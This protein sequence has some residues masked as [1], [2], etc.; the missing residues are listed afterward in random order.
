MECNRYFIR[1]PKILLVEDDYVVQLVHSKFLTSLGCE[2]CLAQNAEEALSMYSDQYDLILLDIGLPD[3]SGL[4][5]SV[6][7]RNQAGTKHM[8]IIALTGFGDIIQKECDKV[9]IDEIAIKPIPANELRKLLSRWL[10]EL[11]KKPY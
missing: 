5:I 2:I 3:V 10:P 9:G 11:V 1:K 8:P 7:I 6:A 4:D